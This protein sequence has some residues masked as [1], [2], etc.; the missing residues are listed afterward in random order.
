MSDINNDKNLEVYM[1]RRTLKMMTVVLLLIAMMLFAGCVCKHEWKDATCTEPKTCTKCGETEGEPLGHSW[2]DATCTE[3]KTCSVCGETEGNAAGHEWTEATVDK[4]KTCTKCGL[5]E[6]E[7]LGFPTYKWNESQST[8]GGLGL[9]KFDSE[10]TPDIGKYGFI[11]AGYTADVK[12]LMMMASSDQVHP[13][14]DKLINIIQH[15]MQYG[16][17]RY[18]DGYD[19]YTNSDWST[20]SNLTAFSTVSKDG[21]VMVGLYS[22]KKEGILHYYDGEVK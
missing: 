7:P 22:N 18:Y 21:A 9:I 5:T 20:G 19:F 8:F 3:P 6:G 11:V 15:T 10:G 16:K 2:I 14:L 4:P 13:G 12:T 17:H 1:G